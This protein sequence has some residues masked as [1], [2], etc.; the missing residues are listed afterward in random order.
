[1]TQQHGL[2]FQRIMGY[3]AIVLATLG[4]LVVLYRLGQVVLL[5]VLSIVVAAALRKGV[6]ALEA[7]HVPRGM[8][9]LLLYLLAIGILG[10]GIY[11]L[12]TPLLYELQTISQELPR[13]YDRL[14]TGFQQQ[15]PP[16]QKALADRL[17]DTDT[18]IK[19]LGSGGAAGIGLQIAGLTSGIVGVA[20][21]VVAVLSLTF[22]WLVD[23]D[24][25]E[26]L[27]LTLLPVQQR[28]VARNTWRGIE[29]RVGA[30]VRSEATQFVLTTAVLWVAFRLLGIGFPTLYAL[31]AGFVQLIPWI[32]IPLTLLPIGFMLVG[33]PWWQIGATAAVV[34]GVGVVMDRIIEP[35][36]RGDAVVHPILTVLALMILGEVAGLTGMII[37]LPLAATFQIVLGELIRVTTSPKTMAVSAESTQLQELRA[38]IEKLGAELPRDKEHRLESEDLFERLQE[39][40][41]HT[42]EVVRE[43][44]AAS[45]AERRR[46][47]RRT[48]PMVSRTKTS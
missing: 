30:Y 33:N 28:S 10:L 6:L 45:Q 39:L 5:F 14:I 11:L 7:R 34:V 37:A 36:L 27:W 13:G 4:T 3:T 25:F 21:S 20:I 22:Y 44:A 47:T 35:R 48:I 8:A 31:Y 1:M 18:V 38:R 29:H 16:W 17:P 2:S 9:I 23:Q 24:R 46:P 15:G 12:V 40:M 26:R 43:R 19:S 41:R 42:E 32:G